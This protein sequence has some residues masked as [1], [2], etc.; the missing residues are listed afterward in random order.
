[1]TSYSQLLFRALQK[2][3]SLCRSSLRSILY[4][5][6]YLWRLFRQPRPPRD[7]SKNFGLQQD[8][9]HYEIY[10]DEHSSVDI[11]M[12]CASQQPGPELLHTTVNYQSQTPGRPT[13]Y[14]ESLHLSVPYTPNSSRSCSNAGDISLRNFS[15]SNRSHT[16]R[17]STTSTHLHPLPRLRTSSRFKSWRRIDRIV[18][19]PHRPESPV[20]TIRIQGPDANPILSEGNLITAPDKRSIIPMAPPLID[21]Y[22]RRIRMYTFHLA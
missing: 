7:Q 3:K 11:P 14:R 17:L 8:R 22:E 21:R 13:S 19:N 1:M 10:P 2:L 5:F 4:F 16:S 15:D 9:I 12:V 20:P 18:E 6:R